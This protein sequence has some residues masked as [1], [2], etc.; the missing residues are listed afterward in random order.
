[1]GVDWSMRRTDFLL[2]SNLVS[3]G[4]LHKAEHSGS[5]G[6]EGQILCTK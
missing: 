5:A 2:F 6:K 3:Q 1:M 4:K